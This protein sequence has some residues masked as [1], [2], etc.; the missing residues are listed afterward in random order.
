MTNDC[1]VVD[2]LPEMLHTFLGNPTR[3]AAFAARPLERCEQNNG[4]RTGVQGL[5][6]YIIPKIDVNVSA[7]FQN[8]PGAQVDAN[9]LA[10]VAATNLGRPFS[11]SLGGNK[12]FN[13]VEAG[14]VYIERLNQIDFRLS[15]LFRVAG[16]RTMVNFDFY[17]VTNS[18]SILSE[19]A[20]YTAQPPPGANPATW[21][22]PTGILLP[23]LFK[24]GMQFDF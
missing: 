2:E 16:T 6:A 4:W 17:N 7:T 12:F 14:E 8:Q 15:K 18:N 5:A 11:G 22:S 20:T 19:N 13:I 3:S 1:D 21:R 24:L 9:W 10:G 23:R